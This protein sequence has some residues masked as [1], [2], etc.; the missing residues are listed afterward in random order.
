MLAP[1]GLQQFKGINAA[2]MERILDRSTL[3]P[4]INGGV[5]FSGRLEANE[6]GDPDDIGYETLALPQN[7]KVGFG[8]EIPEGQVWFPYWVRQEAAFN[9]SSSYDCT[10]SPIQIEAKYTRIRRNVISEF[11]WGVPVSNQYAAFTG[12]QFPQANFYRVGENP[13][14]L[15]GVFKPQLYLGMWPSRSTIWFSI[16]ADNVAGISGGIDRVFFRLLVNIVYTGEKYLEMLREGKIAD[17][18]LFR[19][20]TSEAATGF[21]NVTL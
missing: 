16:N 21:P 1:S 5:M 4:C 8:I 12:N 18:E 13:H 7:N 6:A 14:N 20:L 15:T 10:F 19:R 11:Q 9:A 3:L 2:L 17:M